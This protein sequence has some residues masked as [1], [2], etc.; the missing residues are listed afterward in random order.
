[1]SNWK[2]GPG[3]RLYHPTTG[4]Y[5][6]QLDLNG[7][8]QMV[9]VTA[10]LSGS[11]VEKLIPSGPYIE[12]ERNQSAIDFM[13]QDFAYRRRGKIGIGPNKAAVAIRFDDGQN[14]AK[15]TI[16]P[17][18]IAR[19]LP[20]SHVLISR[21]QT[22]VTWGNTA[23]P[24]DVTG[25]VNQGCEIFSH[26]YDHQDY[27]GYDGLYGN[28]VGSKN[29]IEALL[30][31]VRVQ[32]FAIPGID[33]TKG[34]YG[35]PSHPVT[36]EQRGSAYPYDLLTKPE[37]WNGPAG[38]LLMS[39]YPIVEAYSGAVRYP[40]SSEPS[41]YMYGRSHIGLD[42]TTLA[43]AKGLVDQA[44][45]EKCSI[46]FMGHPANF[47][48]SESLMTVADLTAF[49][50][51]IVTK[52][53]AG[54]VEVVMPSSLPFVTNQSDRLDL[55]QG[56][57]SLVGVTNTPLSGW[58][59]LGGIYN[60]INPDGG[61]NNLPNFQM[62]ASGDH[63]S[64]P[65]YLVSDCTLQGFA[66]ESFEFRGWAQSVDAVNTHARIDVVAAGTSWT[67]GRSVLV[68]ATM[69]L[70]RLPFTLPKI[71]PNGEFIGTVSIKPGRWGG[72]GIKWSDMSVVKL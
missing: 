69:T 20:F 42:Y 48:T 31:T 45:R 66:G 64:Q 40:I 27:I 43:Q 28:V 15:A 60:I 62:N 44:I 5:V 37:M 11:E 34:P 12:R 56:A 61:H 26:G 67:V 13:R 35:D 4:A 36:P 57:G 58:S 71:G 10:T 6:G 39:H 30:P 46:R 3:G 41:L 51:Y 50:D 17:L 29:E 24:A 21:W 25:W 59:A 7:N 53:D 70:V 63:Y 2:V 55:M 16:F 19:Q 52:R 14:A 23:T 1:M 68:G 65:E 22:A 9:P 18:M 32:G 8:E 49:L 33:L 38:R 47:G 54:L 72:S